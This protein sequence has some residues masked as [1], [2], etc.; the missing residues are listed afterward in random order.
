MNVAYTNQG[1]AL[2]CSVDVWSFN[3]LGN[4]YWQTRKNFTAEA[5]TTTSSTPITWWGET[6]R[7]LRVNCGQY[8]SNEIEW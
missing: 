7:A 6:K 2:S 5:K 8:A 1:K 3:L 4:G